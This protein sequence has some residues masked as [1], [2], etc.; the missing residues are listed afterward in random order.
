MTALSSLMD[1]NYEQDVWREYVANGICK[2]VH[3]W[4]K[5]SNMP[6]YDALKRNAGRTDSRSGQEIVNSI[7]EKRRR[8]K[9]VREARKRNEPIHTIC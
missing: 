4:A 8:K 7:V 5:N 3:I 9:A 1:E 6:Y 2:I